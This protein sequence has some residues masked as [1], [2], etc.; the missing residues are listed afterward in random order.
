MSR[1]RVLLGKTGEDLACRELERRGYEILARRYRIR[2]AEL[3]IVARDGRTLVFVEVKTRD[4]AGFGDGAEAV[5]RWKQ[6]RNVLAAK[7][8]LMMHRLYDCP[9]RFDVVSVRV[10]GGRPEID[11]FPNAFLADG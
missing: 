2:G 6:R 3:D 5:T 9:C 8:F 7:H 1:A 4:G 11:V 10:D